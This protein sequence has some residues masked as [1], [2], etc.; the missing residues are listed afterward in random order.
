MY[1]AGSLIAF[2]CAPGTIAKDGKG[3]RNG[4]FTKCLL[5]HITAKNKDIM[6]I[7]FDVTRDVRLESNEKQI[8]FQCMSLTETI[9]L[10]P[11]KVK[12]CNS[13]KCESKHSQH[14]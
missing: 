12:S 9:Y 4:L 1:K 13:I 3:Q 2:A 5:Q 11:G 8:P 14:R 7:L 10:Q 6:K